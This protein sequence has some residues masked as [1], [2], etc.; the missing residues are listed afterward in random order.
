L[1]FFLL[2]EIGRIS[3]DILAL[4]VL[5]FLLIESIFPVKIQNESCFSL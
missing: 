3:S 1:L 5:S 4:W 2:P